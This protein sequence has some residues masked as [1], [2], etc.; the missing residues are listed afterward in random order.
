MTEN[1]VVKRGL[2]AE[3]YIQLIKVFTLS[4]EEHREVMNSLNVFPVPDADTGTNMYISVKGIV[5]NLDRADPYQD[6]N[7]LS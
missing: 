7:L 3:D 4:L 2:D 1:T 5:D 6:L